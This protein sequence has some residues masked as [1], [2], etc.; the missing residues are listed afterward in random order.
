MKAI[1]DMKQFRD[2]IYRL[3]LVRASGAMLLRQDLRSMGAYFIA[4]AAMVASIA[5]FLIWRKVMNGGLKL[6]I[7]LRPI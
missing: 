1:K 5:G 2:E 3:E 6:D 4:A 7:S